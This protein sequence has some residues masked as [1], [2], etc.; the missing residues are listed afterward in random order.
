MT[1]RDEFLL[2]HKYP[3]QALT[4]EPGYLILQP[5]G[6][7]GDVLPANWGAAAAAREMIVMDDLPD[8]APAVLWRWLQAEAGWPRLGHD[9]E[10]AY[11]RGPPARA[12]R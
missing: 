2:R 4:G 1:L 3:V 11:R 9:L 10:S 7:W 6:G 12:A 8:N 5:G